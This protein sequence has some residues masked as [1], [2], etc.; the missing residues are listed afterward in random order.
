EVKSADTPS[1]ALILSISQK[2]EVDLDYMSEVS[3]IPKDKLIS[4]LEGAIFKVPNEDN[5]WVTQDEYLSGNIREKLRIAEEY[6]KDD[7]SYNINVSALKEVMPEDITTSEINVR[8]GA[9]WIPPKYYEQFLFEI[10]ESSYYARNGIKI[11]YSNSSGEWYIEGKHHDRGS[12]RVN[13]TYGTS[14]ANAY[15]LFEDGLNL[16][17]TKIFDYKIDELGKKIPV[18][19][20][21]ETAIAQAKHDKRDAEF[22]EW[23]WK[24]P[25]RREE[26]TRL[27]NEK[28]NSIR[29]REYD[30][31]HITFDGMNP[32]IK[33]RKHQ[34]NAIAR[35]LYG[36]NT[37]LAH[38]VGAGK[39][40]EMVA[41]A[42]ESKRLGLCNKSLFVVPNHIIE[43]FASEFLQL[44]PSANILVSTK[45]DF[46]TANR[47]KF[48][49]RIATGDYD[50]VIIG[51]SQFE[52]IPMSV[53]RQRTMLNN[54]LNEI[55]DGIEELKKNNSE[56]FT[57]KQMIR[58]KKMLEKKLEKLNSSNRKDDV[59]TFEE[60][61]VDRL[62]VDE[63][64][65]YKNLFLYTKMRNV[66]GIAQTEAQKSSDL[67]MKCRYLDEI[68]GN[69]GV[70]F[71]TGT[72]ISNSMVELYTM[73]RYLQYDTLVKHGLQHFDAWASTFGEKVTAV[74][75]S[76]EGNGYRSKT[77][78][79][80]FYNLPELMNMFKE[81]ADIQTADTLNLPVPKAHYEN[82]VVKPSEIQLEYVKSFSER[83]EKVRNK[84][85]KINE[86]NMLKITNDGR[87]LAL[88]QRLVDARL[89][90]EED[91]KV[92]VCSK[93]V[94]KIWEE[95]RDNKLTQ[96]VFCDLSTP[97]NDG[98]FN[99]YD[100]IKN[101]L[102]AR[103]VPEEEIQFIH[104]AHTD[105][106]KKEMFAKV[107][108]GQV[109][110]LI[111]STPKMGAGTNCQDKLLALHDLDC[112]WRPS[113]LIQRSGRIVRQGNQNDDV[114]IYRYVTEKT[115]DAYLYQLVENKQKFMSQIMTSKTPVRTAEDIDEVALSY[116]EIKALAAG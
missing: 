44:Y 30:G 51:H 105:A 29:L 46:E 4:D 16:R 116:A 97:K 39:T 55:V 73:Q 56:R 59:I 74:E 90:D 54:Q 84:E 62:F 89:P 58:T 111:G 35:I 1:D 101:K 96:L 18:F 37:L 3:N 49:S 69:K 104:N 94:Y 72:P 17:D 33:L 34:I 75:L 68:T 42:M 93:N 27:Y 19:N 36:G 81:V 67:Q 24:D 6:A 31:S 113:D 110:I 2:A 41:A 98:T 103:G 64:H 8:F 11:H 77:R 85:V 70:I 108:K 79:A 100:D 48:C 99:V 20:K 106:Q 32:E 13:T 78:F 87:K 10:L 22:I 82:I 65:Y 95:N 61:G 43:Q 107:R 86:D 53:A 5:R 80:R 52:R 71:A 115:F 23:I 14:R 102:L 50:A 76:P 15:K 112:P 7:P 26:L 45:K 92:D 60:L 47:K 21:K 63:A 88:D 9:T 12:V 57:I 38:E 83:A 109:R 114:Y 40:F 91:S 28:F 25:D 66:A